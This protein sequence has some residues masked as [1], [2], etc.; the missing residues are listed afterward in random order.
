MSFRYDE[1]LHIPIRGVTSDLALWSDTYRCAW[2]GVS[3][4][5]SHDVIYVCSFHEKEVP[6]SEAARYFTQFNESYL[7]PWKNNEDQSKIITFS[8]FLTSR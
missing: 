7:S 6:Q 8:H 1:S 2:T 4:R 3:G 5:G